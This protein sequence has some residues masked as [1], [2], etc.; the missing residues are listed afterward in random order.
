MDLY[1]LVSVVALLSLVQ[2]IAG[3]GLL[4]FGT[5]TLLIAGFQYSEA[6]WILLPA[7]CSLSLLQIFENYHRIE[8]KTEVF[9]LTVPALLVTL[10]VILIF[11]YLIAI[12][13]IVGIFLIVIGLMRLRNWSEY[14]LRQT[15]EKG[16]S[17]IYIAIGVIHG[18]SNLGGAPLTVLASSTFSEKEQISSNIAFVYF[19]LALSQLAVLSIFKQEFFDPMFLMLVPISILT[20]L[21]CGK[22][23]ISQIDDKKFN[24][25]INITILMFGLLCFS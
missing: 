3:I 6:L 18:M 22:N 4:L 23:L 19:V 2:S 16:K 20:H 13:K 5:P 17:I 24:V 14:F 21:I 7:S 12:K 25:I 11:D 1:F 15:V 9:F 8:S 10:T